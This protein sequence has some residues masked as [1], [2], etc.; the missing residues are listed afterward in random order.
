MAERIF[1]PA[2]TI[3]VRNGDIVIPHL[4]EVAEH[5]SSTSIPPER[6][7]IC[8]EWNNGKGCIF[9][10]EGQ[11]TAKTQE[12]LARV[13][14][15]VESANSDMK[16]TL[17]KNGEDSIPKRQRKMWRVNNILAGMVANLNIPIGHNWNRTV[18]IK[19][20]LYVFKGD[21]R[22]SNDTA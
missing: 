21:V 13:M 7:S 3:T 16:K 2:A 15:Y 5:K 9:Y 10:R 17:K 6:R 19:C 1:D 22:I 20:P 11:C 8:S 14:P 18:S 4:R 12:G